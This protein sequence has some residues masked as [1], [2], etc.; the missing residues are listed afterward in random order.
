MTQLSWVEFLNF[1]HFEKFGTDFATKYDFHLPFELKNPTQAHHST[2][3]NTPTHRYPSYHISVPSFHCVYYSLTQP[4]NHSRP[5]CAWKRAL[6]NI[7]ST[8]TLTALT[9]VTIRVCGSRQLLVKAYFV[10]YVDSNLPQTAHIFFSFYIL[11][12]CS[13]VV[14]CK[15]SVF[16]RFASQNDLQI[17]SF[18]NRFSIRATRCGDWTFCALCR[19][20]WFLRQMCAP[21]TRMNWKSSIWSRRSTRIFI[22][23]WKL[24]RFDLKFLEVA[25][26]NSNFIFS[27]DILDCHSFTS[28]IGI[29]C[30]VGRYTSRQEQSRRC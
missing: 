2:Q 9:C 27:R 29:P 7:N 5:R 3:K 6:K 16:I 30:T 14:N 15:L 25:E 13:A 22:P 24:N 23:C 1:D 19:W 10:W 17:G 21:G 18:S 11:I 28:S 12:R 8:N 4:I 20:F 26:E